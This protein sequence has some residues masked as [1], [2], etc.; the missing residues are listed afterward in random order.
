VPITVR[1]GHSV[2]YARRRL[3]ARCAYRR[4]AARPTA[5]W[6]RTVHHRPSSRPPPGRVR[7]S[8]P[9]EHGAALV[10]KPR[11]GAGVDQPAFR[12]PRPGGAPGRPQL[13]Q[14]PQRHGTRTNTVLTKIGPVEVE[15]RYAEGVSSMKE[16]GRSPATS[17][18]SSAGATSG[19]P[20]PTTRSVASTSCGSSTARSSSR[21]LLEDRSDSRRPGELTDDRRQRQ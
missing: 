6:R 14:L 21:R 12:R 17:G 15:V 13:R 7:H 18:R 8:Y 3:A 11:V 16:R 20:A 19:A 10:G 5:A 4:F 1:T 2:R 9:G